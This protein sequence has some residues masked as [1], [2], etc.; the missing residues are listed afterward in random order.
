MAEAAYVPFGDSGLEVSRL[1]LGTMTFGDQTDEAGAQAQVNRALEAGINFF[2]TADMYSQGA[3]EEILGRALKA[4]K[5]G[6]DNV[7]VASKVYYANS[8]DAEDTGLSPS[9]ILRCCEAS[10]KRLGTDHLDLYQLHQPDTNTPI[11]DTLAT[12]EQL[13]CEGKVRHVGVSNFAAW[14]ICEAVHLAEWAGW[15]PVVSMQMMYNL[16]S[17]AIEP[18]LLPFCRKYGLGTMV[19][20]P[21]AGGLLTGKH[22]KG[23]DPAKNTRFGLKP[24]YRDR[25]WHESLFDATAKLKAI[26]AA[27]GLSLIELS[28]QWLLAQPD[29][30]CVIL[31]ASTMEQLE[32]NLAACRGTLP[33][34]VAEQCDAVYAG[35]HGPIPR[36]NR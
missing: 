35:L 14:Q 30:T 32:Q 26:A 10:L 15:A 6:R 13:V 36:Y 34:G 23:K 9:R 29:V 4:S 18:E 11:E 21:L 12:M 25:F 33:D 8:D 28:F 7:I 2:D 5:A 1:V 31:G 27:T 16:L 3:S 20:N 17:R 22:A 19:Y 24:M